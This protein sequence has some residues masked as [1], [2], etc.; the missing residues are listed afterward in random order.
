MNQ[1]FTCGLMANFVSFALALCRE[2]SL[3]RIV[4]VGAVDVSKSAVANG[5]FL[6][7]FL[8][9]EELRTESDRGSFTNQA[10]TKP[11]VRKIQENVV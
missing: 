5:R 3:Y 1:I 10:G 8:C 7:T 6:C 9:S 2:V 4:I 11:G